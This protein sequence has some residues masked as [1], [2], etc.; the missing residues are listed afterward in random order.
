MN[1]S[2][3][4]WLDVPE[5]RRARPLRFTLFS[6]LCLMTFV[7][8]IAR[9]LSK[10]PLDFMMTTGLSVSYMSSAALT[11]WFVSFVRPRIVLFMLMGSLASLAI[12]L[13]AATDRVLFP[14]T[15]DSDIP[16]ILVA[17]AISIWCCGTTFCAFGL[18]LARRA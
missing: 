7:A 4:I 14:I 3:S 11:A 1:N 10:A 18:S 17:L 8:P 16:V 2:E 12:I 5:D 6:L 15:P 9:V 13:I